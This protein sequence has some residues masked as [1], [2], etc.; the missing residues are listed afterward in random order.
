[1]FLV[2]R[3]ADGFEE[4][5]I[6]RHSANILRRTCILPIQ[7]QRP[8]HVRMGT[9]AFFDLDSMLPVVAVVVDVSE[10]LQAV[11]RLR[12]RDPCLVEQRN[13]FPDAAA[14][15]RDSAGQCD[16]IAR[17]GSVGDIAGK[18]PVARVSIVPLCPQDLEQPWRQH[19]VVILSI[20]SLVHADD[21]SPAVDIDDLQVCDLG[22]TQARGVRGHQDGALPETDDRLEE[23][24]DFLQAE[25][26]RQS[27]RL[28]WEWKVLVA[29]V[30]SER[31]A[32]EEAQCANRWAETGGR[33]LAFFAE[34]DEPGPDV[35]GTQQ[36]GRAAKVPGEN[37]RSAADRMSGCFLPGF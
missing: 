31:H 4:V 7:A 6:S 17:N 28:P 8:A 1:V 2:G 16:R 32:V 18:K 12:Q 37:W 35:L 25:N 5:S 27:D 3:I 29:R 24:R 33:Q 22:N 9:S 26:D 19:H 23:G 10:R 36:F 13:G 11:Q 20:F 21:H 34:V 14:L 30:A 15:A